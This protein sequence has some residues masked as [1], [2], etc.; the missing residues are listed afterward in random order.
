MPLD[1]MATDEVGPN[2]FPDGSLFNQEEFEL[3]E[4]IDGFFVFNDALA[5]K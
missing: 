5:G 2:D 3:E 4:G 1:A